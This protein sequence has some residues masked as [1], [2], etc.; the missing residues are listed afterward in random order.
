MGI[1]SPLHEPCHLQIVQQDDP[2]IANGP[3]AT[4]SSKK[5]HKNRVSF[6]SNVRV[7]VIESSSSESKHCDDDD[8]FWSV[9][10]S[11]SR[12]TPKRTKGRPTRRRKQKITVQRVLAQQ[13]MERK[14]MGS[15]N[16]YSLADV[17]LLSSSLFAQEAHLAALHCALEIE[18]YLCSDISES[19]ASDFED[20]LL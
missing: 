18:E 19:E 7:Q 5:D 17:S 2:L 4:N 14:S 9:C 13:A 3:A 20:I 15:V 1:P 16:P 10:N 12:R 8:D 11:P 6:N